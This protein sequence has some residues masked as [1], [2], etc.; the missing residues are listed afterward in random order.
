MDGYDDANVTGKRNIKGCIEELRRPSNI[1]RLGR[2]VHH[3]E[4]DRNANGVD[5]LFEVKIS[6]KR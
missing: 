1:G 3:P 6:T 4:S 2:R 5:A